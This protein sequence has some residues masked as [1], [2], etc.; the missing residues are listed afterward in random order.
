VIVAACLGMKQLIILLLLATLS[1]PVFAQFPLGSKVAD[2][3]TYFAGNIPYASVQEFKTKAGE[4]AI[5]FTKVKVV[6][7]YT[8][9]FDNNGKCSSYVV[10]YDEN[11]LKELMGRF[12]VKFCRMQETQWVAQDETFD[13]TLLPAKP[14]ENFF[15]IVYKQKSTSVLTNAFAAN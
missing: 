15:S 9:Y 3:K 2:I 13:V 1:L 11:E 14:G 7:D 8:F 6:G 5:C 4:D 12:D 10:T